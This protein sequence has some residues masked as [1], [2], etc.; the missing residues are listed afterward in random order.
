LQHVYSRQVNLYRCLIKTAKFNSFKTT[1]GYTPPSSTTILGLL[2]DK[3]YKSA[4]IEVKAQ[5]SSS[6]FLGLVIDEFTNIN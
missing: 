1:F 3:F 5:L 6:P 2:L 4:K